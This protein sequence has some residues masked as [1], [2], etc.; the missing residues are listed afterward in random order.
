MYKL[1][2]KPNFSS[3][4]LPTTLGLPKLMLV[5]NPSQK[6]YFGHRPVNHKSISKWHMMSSRRRAQPSGHPSTTSTL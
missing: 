5:L 3:L 4:H 1:P 2:T 6:P